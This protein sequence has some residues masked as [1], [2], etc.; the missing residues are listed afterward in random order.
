H[1]RDW[2]STPSQRRH[3][4]GDTKELHIVLHSQRE[5]D[6]A[7]IRSGDEVGTKRPRLRSRLRKSG[8]VTPKL[9]RTVP[10][11]S[12]RCQRASPPRVGA[13]PSP[14]FSGHRSLP[15]APP[16]ICL[17]LQHS[18]R[19]A[20]EAS[21]GVVWSDREVEVLLR[22]LV[23]G[24]GPLECLMCPGTQRHQ[25][26]FVGVSRYMA[27]KGFNRDHRQC[28]TKFKKL[29]AAYFA[30]CR[31]GQ[32]H[33][34]EE[35]RP[36]WYPVMHQIWGDAGRPPVPGRHAES[37]ML[38]PAPAAQTERRRSAFD[39]PPSGIPS[40]KSLMLNTTLT[41]AEKAREGRAVFQRWTERG[42]AGD[43]GVTR[44]PDVQISP[45]CANKDGSA[46]LLSPRNAGGHLLTGMS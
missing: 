31:A 30:L 8:Y 7:E 39:Q 38:H 25:F 4:R 28:R 40:G 23:R 46:A 27:R 45:C 18:L 15:V 37:L 2:R 24:N 12:Q 44:V 20:G 16:P 22:V 42:A 34:P 41:L 32:G 1:A 10:K 35:V 17:A 11:S 21:R 26:F 29:R 13:K 6:G 33:P 43:M 36:L 14:S 19:M 3:F 9:K 5:E